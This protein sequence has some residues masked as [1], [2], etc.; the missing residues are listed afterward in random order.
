MGEDR[1]KIRRLVVALL[2]TAGVITLLW[3]LALHYREKEVLLVDTV[4][5]ARS[6]VSS[7]I[8]CKGRVEHTIQ[9]AVYVD[10]TMRIT[11][12]Y[13]EEGDSVSQ[14][15]VLMVAQYTDASTSL[16]KDLQGI[17][18]QEAILA[19]FSNY[20]GEGKPQAEGSVSALTDGKEDETLVIKSPVS[21]LVTALNVTGQSL[22]NPATSL[23]T[24][25]DPQRKQVRASIAEAYIQDV[26]VGM[27]CTITGDG[28]RDR[29]YT[30][31]VTKIMPYAYQTQTLTGVGDTVVDVIV[32]I[33]NADA[34]LLS[35][36]TAQ[37]KIENDIREDALLVPYEAVRQDK[38][39][40]EY[41]Y[42]VENGRAVR[43]DIVTGYEL[44]DSIELVS[45]ISLGDIVIT[46]TPDGLQNGRPVRWE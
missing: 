10:G 34:A 23:V 13:V 28:F 6:D 40:V 42:V 31:H 43:K 25:A 27:R 11:D 12:V 33:D 17:L 5:V 2:A 45:G 32:Q 44:T 30:G 19:V 38:N 29:T 20:L 21:G 7:T 8:I 18:D 35:G 3:S 39:N 26:A 36:V 1:L 4:A 16:E 15:D 9:N 37:V 24:V 41:V 46:S 22:V 14:G